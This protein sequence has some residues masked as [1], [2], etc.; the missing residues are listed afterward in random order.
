MRK[1]LILMALVATYALAQPVAVRQFLFRLEPVRGGFTL[2]N[3]TEAERPVVIE[4]A[5]YL[6]SMLDEGKLV[7]AG[8]AFDPAGFWGIVIVN[9]PDAEAATAMLNADP[10]IKSKMFRGTAVPFRIVF[11]R[12][13]EP[14]AKK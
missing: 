1:A 7:L 10:A 11:S 4:H 6:K 9:A 2:Q 5:A 12:T 13:P 8:Q 3:M 14:A